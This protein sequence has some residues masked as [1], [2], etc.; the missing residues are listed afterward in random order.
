MADNQ[1]TDDK[2][3]AVMI[4]TKKSIEMQTPDFKEEL[5]KLI[6]EPLVLPYAI[7]MKLA[8]DKQFAVELLDWFESE[9]G[10]K[11]N[12]FESRRNDLN[13]VTH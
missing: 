2:Q 3:I 7:A 9:Y 5:G 10:N 4:F 6:P 12:S 8:C 11:I 1:V 13:T